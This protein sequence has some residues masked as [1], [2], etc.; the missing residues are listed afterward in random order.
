MKHSSSWVK[1]ALG[2][3]SFLL[4]TRFVRLLL[5]QIPSAL[6]GRVAYVVSTNTTTKRYFQTKHILERVGFRVT[7]IRPYFVGSTMT[8]QT[9]SNKIAILSAVERIANGAHSWGYVFED[10]IVMHERSDAKLCDIIALEQTADR[11]QYLGVCIHRGQP[12]KPVTCGR[13]A[14]AMGF[15]REG[16]RE[17]LAFSQLEKSVKPRLMGEPTIP[18][19]E[20]YLDVIVDLWCQDRNGFQVSPPLIESSKS[21]E[22]G[23]VGIFIQDRNT[24]KSIISNAPQ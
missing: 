12:I 14:H 11:F 17:L 3:L 13:C 20:P 8:Q 19:R 15:S 23:H 22:K 5:L 6:K 24:F 1:N 18:A 2:I 4:A 10:D 21:T 9:F 16:A 7:H